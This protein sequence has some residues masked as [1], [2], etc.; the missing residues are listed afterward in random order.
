MLGLAD[1]P[2]P[3][4]PIVLV[5]VEGGA[6]EHEEEGASLEKHLKL[7]REGLERD[8]AAGR[9]VNTDPVIQIKLAR[10][11]ELEQRLDMLVC[12]GRTLRRD[13]ILRRN[14]GPY[15]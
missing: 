1:A 4:L 3:V 10:K 7:M 14:Y 13:R 5:Q 2:Q 8:E 15:R 9:D 11:K 12:A 6:R